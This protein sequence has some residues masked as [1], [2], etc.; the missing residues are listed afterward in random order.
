MIRKA[1]AGAT[2]CFGSSYA[3]VGVRQAP[4]KLVSPAWPR[5]IR[6]FASITAGEAPPPVINSQ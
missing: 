5:R 6:R 2:S 4:A 1:A 3:C